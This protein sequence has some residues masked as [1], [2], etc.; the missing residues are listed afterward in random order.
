MRIIP[1]TPEVSHYL[2]KISI[3]LE[4][5]GFDDVSRED[6]L[7]NEVTFAQTIEEIP[8]PIK[9]W[10]RRVMSALEIIGKG[11]GRL[12]YHTY[13]TTDRSLRTQKYLYPETYKNMFNTTYY[14]DVVGVKK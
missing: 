3:M 6:L 7:K 4:R 9:S 2:T 12:P 13:K 1:Q 5:D 8:E 10:G 11:D 14:R